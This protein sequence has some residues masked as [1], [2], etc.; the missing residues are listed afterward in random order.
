MIKVFAVYLYA[1]SIGKV[2]LIQH[3][4]S[5]KQAYSKALRLKEQGE[6]DVWIM[7]ERMDEFSYKIAMGDY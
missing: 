2:M 7:E 5:L 4:S 3:Y 1:E 6:R